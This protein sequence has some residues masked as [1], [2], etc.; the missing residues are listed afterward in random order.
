MQRDN[1][2]F[3]TQ[4]RYQLE[5]YNNLSPPV[6]IGAFFFH[7]E[8]MTVVHQTLQNSP[9]SSE[10]KTTQAQI[11]NCCAESNL[12]YNYKVRYFISS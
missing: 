10:N 9:D 11:S 12:I 2:E 4:K 3:Q 6:N 8:G 7:K 5:F 1:E